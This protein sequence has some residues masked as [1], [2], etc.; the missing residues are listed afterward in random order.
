MNSHVSS[1][2]QL[3]GDARARQR[4]AVVTRKGAFLL[5]RIRG[6]E[7]AP[8]RLRGLRGTGD[9]QKRPAVRRARARQSRVAEPQNTRVRIVVA[10]R[11]RCAITP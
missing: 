9:D 10:R 4:H 6:V 7:S 5:M 8:V 11:V 2:G 1:G 3:S